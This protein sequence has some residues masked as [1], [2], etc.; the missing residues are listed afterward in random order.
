[1]N[2]SHVS[3]VKSSNLKEIPGEIDLK[4]DEVTIVSVDVI[5]MYPSIKLSTIKK[6]VIFFSRKVTVVTKKTINICLELIRFGMSST[7]VC[8]DGEYYE[9]HGGEKAEHGLV[10]GRYESAFLANLVAYYLFEKAKA[11][12]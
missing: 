3:T 10:I 1:M 4:R 8:F 7:L 2:Y 5:N 6:A 11:H 9:Y 12:F